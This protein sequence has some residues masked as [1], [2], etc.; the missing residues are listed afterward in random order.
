MSEFF[1]F[2][3]GIMPRRKVIVK[4]DTLPDPKYNSKLVAKF[5]NCLMSNG[6]KSVAES[7]LYK[8]LDMVRE[9]TDQEPL[10]IF[11]QALN[12][13]KPRLEV[14][15]RRVGGTTFQV[16][17]DVKSDRKTA[18]GI[19]WLIQSARGRPE[20]TM[21]ERLAGE[22]VDASNEQG[23]AVKRKVD[24]HRMAEANKAFSHYK[25]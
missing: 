13:V 11:R 5:I 8:S 25:W 10:A 18:L 20:K 7:I 16:P 22:L 14:K 2:G 12:N 24:T 3:G 1:I 15:S 9:R 17:M 21:Q 4:R 23:N 6:K 19:R